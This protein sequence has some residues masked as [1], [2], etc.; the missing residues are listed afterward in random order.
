[1]SL[2]GKAASLVASPWFGHAIT[3]VIVLNAIVI[4]L[5]TSHDLSAAYGDVFEALNQFFLLVFIVEAL[6]KMIALA[7]NVLRYFQDGWNISTSP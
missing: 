7:P 4:G 6:I 3:A 5:D 2:T 1:M